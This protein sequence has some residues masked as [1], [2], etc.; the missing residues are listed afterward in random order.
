MKVQYLG[1]AGFLVTN[2]A[3]YSCLMDPW[4][5]ADGA[6]LKSW[7]QFPWNHFLENEVLP[8]DPQKTILYLSH[9]HED[10][11]DRGFLAKL[12]RDIPIFFPDFKRK[13]MLAELESMGFQNLTELDGE[14]IVC[15]RGFQFRLIIDESFSNEDSGIYILDEMDRSNFLNMNDCRAYEDLPSRFGGKIDLFTVQFSGASWYPSVY[16][17]S[18][19][20]KDAR[21]KSKNQKKFRNILDLAARLKPRMYIPSA[22]PVCFLDPEL[23]EHGFGNPSPF[24]DAPEFLEQMSERVSC[25]HLSPGDCI[26]VQKESVEVTRHEADF[27]KAYE[28]KSAY[29]DEY[30]QGMEFEI[31]GKNLPYY[32]AVLEDVLREKMKSWEQ[33]M[34]HTFPKPSYPKQHIVVTLSNIPDNTPTPGSLHYLMNWKQGKPTIIPKVPEKNVYHYTF[35][36]DV[37]GYAFDHNASWESLMLSLRFSVRR[38]P[39]AFDPLITDFMRLEPEDLAHYPWPE[40]A[41]RRLTVT[42]DGEEYEIDATC[43]HQGAQLSAAC[44]RSNGTIVCPR[45]GWTFDLKKEGACRETSATLNAKKKSQA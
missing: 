34:L 14:C 12:P 13:H 10:H 4:L 31:K 24:P 37:L 45:H 7:Y 25:T 6:F 22:G 11:F 40:P 17:Y 32:G 18:Q 21:A 20:E 28:E 27:S 35:D 42:Y 3:G 8:V 26:D 33:S 9:H 38:A 23:R 39:D 15:T 5:S 16:E 29:L 36:H 2:K 44:L 41:K 43:P 30:A 1:H 19:E